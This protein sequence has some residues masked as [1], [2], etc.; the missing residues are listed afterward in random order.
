MQGRVRVELQLP[1][2]AQSV[3]VAHRGMGEM[4]GEISLLKHGQATASIVADEDNTIL[5]V[6]EGKFL[7]SLFRTEPG[8]PSRFYCFL[9][10]SQASRLRE[11]S[12]NV[13]SAKKPEVHASNYIRLS[14]RQIMENAAFRRILRKF[15]LKELD[16]EKRAGAKVDSQVAMR[17]FDLL[18]EITQLQAA[19]ESALLLKL[20]AKTYDIFLAVDEEVPVR[21]PAPP[22][23]LL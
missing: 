9:A 19:P 16:E 15:L 2:H 1:K 12:N 22:E 20:A 14:I 6:L 21:V 13:G 5:Y 18:N 7:D 23:S 10:T 11:L 3:V 17:A 4:F 8:L